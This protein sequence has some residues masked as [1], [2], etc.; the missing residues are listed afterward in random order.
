MNYLVGPLGEL[1]MP[2]MSES[3]GLAGQSA[4]IGYLPEGQRR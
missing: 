2:R 3:S 4:I 1:R